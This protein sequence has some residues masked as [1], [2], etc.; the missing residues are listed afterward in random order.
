MSAV[1]EGLRSSANRLLHAVHTMK[2]ESKSRKQTETVTRVKQFILAL[3]LEVIV[4]KTD[5]DFFRF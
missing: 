2:N 3:N 5:P 1:G 4:A